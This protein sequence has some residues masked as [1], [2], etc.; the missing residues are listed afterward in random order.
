VL[1]LV[2]LPFSVTPK[3]DSVPAHL[4]VALPFVVA[5]FGSTPV[6]TS[7]VYSVFEVEKL[8]APVLPAIVWTPLQAPP[9]EPAG[10]LGPEGPLGPLSPDGPLG[11]LGPTSD[12]PDG[13]APPALGPKICHV[14]VLM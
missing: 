7:D 1:L 4:T 12:T 3:P 5:V 11:P 14:A 2:A 9:P 8:F 13:H 6:A 10:P